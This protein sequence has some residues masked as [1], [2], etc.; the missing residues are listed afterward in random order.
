MV[1]KSKGFD[2]RLLEEIKEKLLEEK[3]EI[4]R[5][6]DE[7]KET[8][9]INIDVGDEADM[10]TIDTTQ[11]SHLQAVDTKR[12]RL[13]EIIHA[14]EKIENGTYGYCESCNCKLPISRIKALPVARYCIKCQQIME[15]SR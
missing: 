7:S 4:E 15:R 13:R 11:E 3:K 2:R 5:W 9:Q 1:R 6:I 14:L 10:A 8:L 12:G